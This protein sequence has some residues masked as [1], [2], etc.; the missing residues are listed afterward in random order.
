MLPQIRV[1]PAWATRKRQL[2]QSRPRTERAFRNSLLRPFRLL[3]ATVPGDRRARGPRLI[4][5]P[6]ATYSNTR[7]KV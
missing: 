3:V 5:D 4:C 6:Q 7:H 1:D 2:Y